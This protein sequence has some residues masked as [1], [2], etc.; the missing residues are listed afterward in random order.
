MPRKYAMLARR[1][2]DAVAPVNFRK[3]PLE[4]RLGHVL[5]NAFRVPRTACPLDRKVVDVGAEDDQG[6]GRLDFVH[7]FL[8]RDRE[9]ISL[10]ARGA[11][12]SPDANRLIVSLPGKKSGKRRVLQRLEALRIAEEIRDADEDVLI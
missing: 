2:V 9:R 10:L 4:A 5:R 12:E 1:P 7:V 6:H 8:K 3:E 11:S